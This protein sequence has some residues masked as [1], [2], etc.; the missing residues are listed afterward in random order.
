MIVSISTITDYL[1]SYVIF[2]Y[3]IIDANILYRIAYVNVYGIYSFEKKKKNFVL[4]FSMQ[5]YSF[6]FYITLDL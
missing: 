1:I 3:K 2:A 5:R 6:L 4:G